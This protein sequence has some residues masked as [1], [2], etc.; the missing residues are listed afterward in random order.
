MNVPTEELSSLP[1]M[2]ELDDVNALW[3]RKIPVKNY[4]KML[5][6]AFD[7]MYMDGLDN[8]RLLVL[9][10][11]PWLIGQ[12]FRIGYLEKALAYVRSR[13]RVWAATGSEI[14]EWFRDQS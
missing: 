2:W 5:T 4:A 1:I 3:N 12:P 9:N 11:H 8:G 14:I 13:K 7:K 6:D 10:L